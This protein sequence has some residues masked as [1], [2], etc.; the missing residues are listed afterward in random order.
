MS[1]GT[2]GQKTRCMLPAGR[3]ISAAAFAQIQAAFDNNAPSE[4]ASIRKLPSL[5]EQ[6]RRHGYEQGISQALREVATVMT[7]L[8]ESRRDHQ[9]W[10]ESM[11][12]AL[13]RK[14]FGN[15]DVDE[16]VARIAAQAVNQ[17]DRS[18]EYITVHVHPGVATTVASRLAKKQRF[19]IDFDVVSD[20]RLC[21][22]A[23]EIHTPFGIVDAGLETQLDALEAA[24]SKDTP[25]SR[26]HKN[27]EA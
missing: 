27:D 3:I 26:E 1:S 16:L 6:A 19:A 22:T 5:H 17:C 4:P 12:F 25:A 18:L 14:I 21:E 2:P 11:V 23:C 10:L 7:N 20:E 24:L 8:R 9:A 15:D 13:L